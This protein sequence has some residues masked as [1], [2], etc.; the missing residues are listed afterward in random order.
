VLD[1]LTDGYN[2]YVIADCI[3]SRSEVDRVY[4][5]KRMRQAGAVITTMESVLFELL[6]RADHSKRKEISSL[7]K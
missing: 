7:V 4:A 6:V 2:V 1:L 5:E 3:G